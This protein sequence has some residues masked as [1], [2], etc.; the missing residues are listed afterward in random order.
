M[1]EILSGISVHAQLTYLSPSLNSSPF[2]LP[3]EQKAFPARLKTTRQ[4]VGY[5]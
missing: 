1:D 3:T 5:S 4:G 2:V